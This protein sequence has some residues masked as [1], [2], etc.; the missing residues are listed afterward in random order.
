M[1]KIFIPKNLYNLT[2]FEVQSPGFKFGQPGSEILVVG[3][4]KKYDV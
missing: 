4:K 1:A 3:A 2:S